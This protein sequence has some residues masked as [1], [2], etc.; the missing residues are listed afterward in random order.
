MGHNSK[1]G[2]R[3]DSGFKILQSYESENFLIY[4]QTTAILTQNN[5]KGTLQGLN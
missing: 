3:G 1:A 5:N 4:R 2:L